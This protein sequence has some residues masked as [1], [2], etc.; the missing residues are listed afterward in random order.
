MVSE[1]AGD[2]VF[3]ALTAIP[4]SLS[5]HAKGGT[6]PFSFMRWLYFCL[7]L[8]QLLNPFCNLSRMSIGPLLGRVESRHAHIHEDNGNVRFQE[9]LENESMWVNSL[10]D[11]GNMSCPKTWTRMDSPSRLL[12]RNGL[13]RRICGHIPRRS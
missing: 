9:L 2:V 13:S 3:V 4:T 1:C 7:L 12:L 8:P 5:L 6:K 11:S 10:K